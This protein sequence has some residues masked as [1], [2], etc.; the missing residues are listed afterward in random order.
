MLK[1]EQNY[2]FRKAM[3]QMHKRIVRK[4][5]DVCAD[6]EF[7][8]PLDS[9]IYLGYESDVTKIAVK[10]FIAYLKTAFGIRASLTEDKSAA[11]LSLCIGK[12]GLGDAN[13]YMGR[14][15]DVTS[16]GISVTAFDE[17]GIAQ[18]LYSLEEKMNTR[19]APIVKC[20]IL[21]ERPKFSPR[22]IHSGYGIDEFPDEYLSACAH[23]GYDAILL[24]VKDATHSA[25][26]ECD[27]NDIVTRAKK[28]GID[29]YAY[30]YLKNFNHPSAEGAK[31]I[32]D[33]IY[34]TVFR[35]IKGLR[36]MVFVGESIEFPSKDPRVTPRRRT[37]LPEDGIPDGRISPGWWPCSDYP[38]WLSL[39]RDSIRA[40]SP[41]ADVVFWTY[42]WG[43]V[44]AEHRL[45]LIEKLP[46][47]ISLLVTFDMFDKYH[48][49][50]GVGQIM[51]YT[52]SHTGPG[53]YFLTEAEAAKRRGI[54]LYSMVN[55]AGR[56]WDYGVAPYEPFPY[57][58]NARH[59][60]M[61]EAREKFGLVG[62]MESHHF[63]FTPSFITRIAKNNFTVGGVPFEEK[64]EQIAREFAGD[65]YETFLRGIKLISDSITYYVPSDENQYGPFRVGPAYPFCL[66]RD[67][68]LPD[69]PGAHFG[70]RIYYT[71]ATSP[72][73]LDY[74][75]KHTAFSI[76]IKGEIE[77]TLKVKKL[78]SDGLRVLKSIKKKNHELEKL[79]NLVAFLI[80]CCVTAVN[81]KKFYVLK[82]KLLTAESKERLAAVIREIERLGEA[83]IKNAESTIP[84]VERDSAIGFEPS[85]LYQC[86]RRGLEWKIKH[87]RYMLKS[88]LDYYRESL[89]L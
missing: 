61:L 83:E 77:E 8:L 50:G 76:R 81:A 82:H 55:T 39:V 24:F 85:M 3:C 38:E 88:E 20:G 30:S 17:R 10:D 29:S 37:D 52:I 31:E 86:D 57:Q 62:L 66:I 75:G 13:G 47:D 26:G 54:R 25:H 71:F 84:I 74:W 58:W 44:E 6:N 72:Q 59:E 23:H 18:A 79:I 12:E 11:V 63:G 22:M 4:T 27:F 51:D 46:T 64:M 28:Y 14:K 42:N 70:N 15:F 80:K 68:K 2:D 32:F 1:K 56:T 16:S 67:L 69:L 40:V 78:L 36:G 89:K 65:E 5:G 41:D 45:A 60:K 87:T 35:E 49:G 21:E 33:D 73:N 9:K 7:E 53:Y 19:R 48:I 34:G 43:Y